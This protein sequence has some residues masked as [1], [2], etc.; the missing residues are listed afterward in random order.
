[1]FTPECAYGEE[2]QKDS[3]GDHGYLD[4]PATSGGIGPRYSAA[5][6]RRREEL[7]VARFRSR[8]LG[9]PSHTSIS[10]APASAKKTPLRRRQRVGVLALGAPNQGLG[11]QFL[12]LGFRAKLARSACFTDTGRG[13]VKARLNPG[14]GPESAD[15]VLRAAGNGGSSLLENSPNLSSTAA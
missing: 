9:R 6:C 14:L 7:A 4:S 15:L 8:G 3:G 11:E 2:L 5:C 10:I 12:L 1:M 13:G